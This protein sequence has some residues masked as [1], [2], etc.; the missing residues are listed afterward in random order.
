LAN[1]QNN[2]RDTARMTAALD[3]SHIELRIELYEESFSKKKAAPKTEIRNP[4][5]SVASH[6][7]GAY[8][9]QGDRFE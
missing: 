6:R 1:G 4:G 2:Q 7:R 9:D 5:S 8:Q 3:P